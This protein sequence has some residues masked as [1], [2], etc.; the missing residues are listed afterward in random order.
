MITRDITASLVHA[1]R[2][3]PVVTILG[4]RQS[5][6]TT[7]A[8]MTFPEMNYASLEAPDIRLAAE[9]DPR[10]F[11]KQ[12]ENGGILD[13]IQRF[14]LLLSYIQGIVDEK[15]STYRFI[16]TGSHQP[17]LHQAISQSLA[18]R[19]AILNLWPFSFPELRHYSENLDPFEL[20]VNGCFPRLH[21]ENLDA[22]RFFNS[23][24]QT[25]AERDV[26]SLLQVQDLSTFQRFLMLLAGRV[27]QVVNFT[28]LSNDTGVSSTTIK[29]W[30]SVLK[31]SFILYELP[32]FFENVGKRVIKSPKLYFTDTGLVASLL[33]IHTIQQAQRDPLRGQLFENL[34]ITEIAKGAFNRGIRPDLFF[35]RDSNGSEVDVLIR[36]KGQLYP[37]EIKSGATFTTEFLKG[38]DLFRKLNLNQVQPGLI[39]YSGD[40]TFTVHDT[41]IMN[42][43]QLPDLWDA[44]TESN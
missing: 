39:L 38:I 44:I 21:Q 16:L 15:D 17:E 36:E 4:P 35:Y 14:P 31:A 24:I 34:I 8:R 30:I 28:S 13:E 1:S 9:A 19:T 6:K 2:E 5:G 3:Y 23:Y 12:F 7:L 20:I 25:Y 43:F 22:R 37:V 10:G 42:P 33:G 18:G 40:Q 27:G 41:R 26:R 29:K 11:L 32:T